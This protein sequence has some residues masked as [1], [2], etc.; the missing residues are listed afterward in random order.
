MPGK[1]QSDDKSPHSKNSSSVISPSSQTKELG[2]VRFSLGSSQ[3]AEFL[4]FNVLDKNFE[5]RATMQLP[6]DAS[7]QR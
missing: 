7:S 1:F 6:A 4:E 3:F 5:S 2:E